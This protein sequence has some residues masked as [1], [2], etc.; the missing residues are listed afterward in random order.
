MRKTKLFVSMLKK[1]KIE[2][3]EE[4]NGIYIKEPNSTSRDEKYNIYNE[5]FIR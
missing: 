1:L 5:N 4:K 3:Y 2:T